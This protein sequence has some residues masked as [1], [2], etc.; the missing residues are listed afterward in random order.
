MEG[1]DFD[2]ARMPIIILMTRSM[3]GITESEMKELGRKVKETEQAVELSNQEKSYALGFMV[4]DLAGEDFF[5][6]VFDKKERLKYKVAP[7]A[8]SGVPAS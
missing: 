3:Q 2:K 5:R 6:K 7:D 4:L 8:G 1:I